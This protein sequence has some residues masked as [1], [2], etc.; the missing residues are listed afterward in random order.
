VASAGAASDMIDLHSY[1]EP[2]MMWHAD[3]ATVLGEY[4]GIGVFIKGHVWINREQ[5]AWGYEDAAAE[6]LTVRYEA[7][8]DTIKTFQDKGLTASIYTQPFDVEIEQ[9]GLLTYDREVM[10]IPLQ[11]LRR[12]HA[13]LLP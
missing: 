7:M 13:K 11:E 4:G 10:K 5:K 6:N 2:G 8:I 9:N 1:P 3:K 12:I